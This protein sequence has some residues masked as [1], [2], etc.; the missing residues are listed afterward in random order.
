MKK[1][2]SQEEIDSLINA[3]S[4]GE[5]LDD[6]DENIEENLNI[7][8]Y[9]FRRP[10][11]LSK[12][13]I[14]SIENIYENFARITANVLS[15]HLRT[16]VE[17]AIGSIEQV[18]YGEFIRSIPN[19]TIL[20]IFRLEPF[21]GPIIMEA[22]SSLGFQFINFLCGGSYVEEFAVRNFTEIEMT[23]IQDVFQMI[24]DVNK[25]VWKDLI[26]LTPLID[27]IESNP[28]LNQTLSYNESIVLITFKVKID[29]FQNFLNLCI[30]YRA[31]DLVVDK[32]RTVQYD[33][34][35]ANESTE[36]YKREIE[37]L[38]VDSD[39]DLDVVLGKTDITIEDFMDIQEG[40]VIQ[41]STSVNDL[42]EMYIEDTLYYHV[43]PGVHNKKLSVQIVKNT[44]EGVDIN[45]Q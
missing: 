9:D 2:L 8:N 32:L 30:P 41:L 17:L 40:D 38:I 25:V 1:V 19:P 18:S 13:H 26:E 21:R 33:N 43:Q 36:K 11:K 5:V 7:K 15:N 20:T 42:L 4:S 14:N 27:K 22:N 37:N 3:L 39:L 28:Q 23:L 6:I 35:D 34:R 45:E 12:D 10:N 31:L 29:E 24:I 16:N 44:G